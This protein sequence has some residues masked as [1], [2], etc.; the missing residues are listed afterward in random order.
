MRCAARNGAAQRTCATF[1]KGER[2]AKMLDTGWRECH[3]KEGMERK[4]MLWKGKKDWK[5]DRNNTGLETGAS[6][7]KG[8]RNENIRHV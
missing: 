3:R 6:F 5:R 1:C 7:W 2:E 8:K 4:G